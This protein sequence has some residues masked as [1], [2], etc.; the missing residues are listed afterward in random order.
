MQDN[1][2]GLLPRLMEGLKKSREDIRKKIDSVLSL[3]NKPDPE[4][5]EELEEV[6]ITADVGVETSLEVIES[7]SERIR[8]DK[9][10]T[11]ENIR[12]ELKRILKEILGS[13]CTDTDG[14]DT[15]VVILVVGVN[16]VGKTT[17]IG[18]LAFLY[19]NR[20]KKVLVA[21]ADTFRAAAI[22][23]LQAW[24]QKSGADVI[25]HSEG[26]TP[27]RLCLTRLTRPRRG[28]RMC[29]S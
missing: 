16:G 24:S 7:L 2:A 18:K 26:S 29:S 17:T 15:P 3:G 10:I 13:M 11:G 12:E 21:A 25:K 5:L 6:L 28:G 23:Q 22:E 1:Q 20:G 19:K 8:R 9:I 14:E 4:M 27:P